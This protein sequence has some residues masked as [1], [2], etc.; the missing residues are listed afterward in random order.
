MAK[1][2]KTDETVE[3]KR[4]LWR[5]R[6]GRTTIVDASSEGKKARAKALGYKYWKAYRKVER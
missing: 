5:D 3:P 6:L 4:Q 1:A 2:K